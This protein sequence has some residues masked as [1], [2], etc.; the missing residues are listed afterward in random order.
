[1]L[2]FLSTGDEHAPGNWGLYD[3][4]AALRWVHDHIESFSGNPS[5][6]TIFGQG[7]GKM[8]YHSKCKIYIEMFGAIGAASAFL[9]LISPLSTGLFHRVIAQSGSPLCSW[10]M[11]NEP[12]NAAYEVAQR[13]GCRTEQGNLEVI[14]CLRKAPLGRLLTSQQQGKI[15]G[16]FPHRMVPVIEHSGPLNGR[17]VPADPKRLISQGNYRRVP[18]MMGYNRDEASFLYPCKSNLLLHINSHKLIET[19][20]SNFKQ[21]IYW[22]FEFFA[23]LS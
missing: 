1:M 17:I 21:T 3:Q 13:L 5:S 20:F 19:H 7:A 12:E 6:V 22:R 15:F 4:L 11:E 2:G 16:E 9:H 8:D 18:L 23:I 10:S 14:R